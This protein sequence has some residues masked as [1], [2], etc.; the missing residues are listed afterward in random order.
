MRE[1]YAIARKLHGVDPKDPRRASMKP[2]QKMVWAETYQVWTMVPDDDVDLFRLIGDV[3]MLHKEVLVQAIKGRPM[4]FNLYLNQYVKEFGPRYHESE[5]NTYLLTL[6][7]AHIF[8][9][10]NKYECLLNKTRVE[11]IM[12]KLFILGE[13]S[14]RSTIWLSRICK[15]EMY[16]KNP[17]VK[18]MHQ[19]C[20]MHSILLMWDL[21]KTMDGGRKNLDWQ[22]EW[23]RIYAKA[24]HITTSLNMDEDAKEEEKSNL[25]EEKVEGWRQIDPKG[26]AI[27]YASFRDHI[28]YLRRGSVTVVGARTST[29]KSTFCMDLALKLALTKRHSIMYFSL[30]MSRKTCVNKILSNLTRIPAARIEEHN[31][32]TQ[33]E[34]DLILQACSVIDENHFVLVDKNRTADQIINLLDSHKQKYDHA[35]DL[36]VIDFIQ[37]ILTNT[38]SKDYREGLNAAIQKLRQYAIQENISLVLVSQLNRE[39][40]SDPTKLP[41][42]KHLA[43]SGLLE[44]IADHV[45]ILYRSNLGLTDTNITEKGTM[46][47]KK[48]QERAEELQ[49]DI[50]IRIVKNRHGPTGVIPLKVD[51]ANG[52]FIC[53]EKHEKY[54]ERSKQFDEQL[55]NKMDAEIA[56]RKGSIEESMK[57]ISTHDLES[58][59]KSYELIYDSLFTKDGEDEEDSELDPDPEDPS[60]GSGTSG[61]EED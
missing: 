48:W 36:V 12:N 42:M 9:D 30:E 32:L 33:T 15:S 38:N 39:A 6:V 19:I 2:M 21:R 58:I 57:D 47:H 13:F 23:N 25:R 5:A 29:G 61:S 11:S 35:P 45:I 43:E 37:L 3:T 55:K 18:V 41:T 26:L 49:S 24:V 46:G 31:S 10:Y 8:S 27:P 20:G 34:K 50:S 60:D 28:P 53:E 4:N 56:K 51:F 44:T 22:N 52:R 16:I 7:I 1:L 17:I 59:E 54:V 14:E 40:E